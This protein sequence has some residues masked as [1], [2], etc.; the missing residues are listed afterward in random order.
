LG[1]QAAAG[2]EKAKSVI[3]MARLDPQQRQWY[4]IWIER[5]LRHFEDG[6]PKT[7][8]SEAVFLFF[9]LQARQGRTAWQIRQGLQ[10]IVFFLA[11]VCERNEVQWERVW[12][13]WRKRQ[14]GPGPIAAAPDEEPKI[15]QS[16]TMIPL[17]IGELPSEAAVVDRLRIVLRTKHY[18]LRTEEAYVHWW[19]KL[20]AFARGEG[21]TH[22]GPSVVQRFLEH[23]AC[24]RNVAAS[25]QNQALNALVFTFREV[26]DRPLGD[27]GSVMRAEQKPRLPV[28]L[29]VEEIS[30]LFANLDGFHRLIAQLLYG[31]GMRLMEGLRLRVKDLDFEYKTVTVREGKGN[32]DRVTMLPECLCV[33]L[34]K[35][36]VQVQKLHA[37][38]LAQGHGEVYLPYALAEKYPNA[39]REWKWQYVFP[40][41]ELSV[42]PRSGH[43]RRHHLGETGMQRAMRSAVLK[44]G[45]N[46]KVSCHTLRHSFATHLLGA[47]QDIRTVQELLGHADLATTELYTHVL[48]RGA[49]AVRSPLDRL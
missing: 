18:S 21:V 34:R 32:K 47:G 23:L 14:R 11:Q 19:E 37:D 43:V 38:D 35:H 6:D 28:V 17:S 48:Q 7:L 39:G 4:A 33:P 31:T 22:L 16:P 29:S 41:R 8:R 25:T 1:R 13:A 9:D 3:Q 15:D 2:L 5:F 46:K 40:A 27:L 12:N 49:K 42:D 45:L 44:S 20:V 30:K 10:A 24:E 26:L 36:L